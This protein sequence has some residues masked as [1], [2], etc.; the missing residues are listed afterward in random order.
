MAHTDEKSNS[1]D[2]STAS[3]IPEPLHETDEEIE[4][5]IEE[6]LPTNGFGEKVLHTLENVAK[7]VRPSVS[8]DPAILEHSIHKPR[9]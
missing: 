1:L 6:L 7:D 8:I 9:L 5:G 3:S 4:A 2:V